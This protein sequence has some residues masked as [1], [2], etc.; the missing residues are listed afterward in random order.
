MARRPEFGRTW[1]GNAWLEALQ[2][3]DYYTNRLPRGRQYAR[4][5]TVSGVVFE[6]CEVKAEVQGRRRYP[7]RVSIRF[8]P[9]TE[10]EKRKISAIIAG[11]PT[12]A[13]QLSLG[14]L[15]ESLLQ[16]M[17]EAGVEPFPEGWDELAASCSCP[18]WAN[19]CK[20]LAAVYYIL[21]NEIDKDPFLV[22]SLRGMAAAELSLA[23]GLAPGEAAA[24]GPA[25]DLVFLLPEEAVPLETQA[26]PEGPDLSLKPTD[27]RD[28]LSLLS[29]SPLFWDKG[30]FK[31]LLLEMYRLV[32]QK[33]DDAGITEDH[34]W[35]RGLDL[36]LV[37]DGSGREDPFFFLFSRSSRGDPELLKDRLRSQLAPEAQL[38][39]LRLKVPEPGEEAMGSATRRG[40]SVRAEDLLPLLMT[41]SPETAE[42]EYRSPSLRFFILA[43]AVSMAFAGAGSFVPRVVP[44]AEHD[45]RIVYRPLLRDSKDEAV[46]R[47]LKAAFPPAA[48]FRVPDGRI[49]SPD[50]VEG[51]LAVLI[52]RMVWG[53]CRGRD[54]S[55]SDKTAQAF[56]RGRLYR[57]GR[58]EERRTR[59]SVVN[60]LAAL[61]SAGAELALLLRI[62]PAGDG[63]RFRLGLEAFSRNDPVSAPLS[64]R[65][66][67]ESEGPVFG[68][69]AEQVRLETARRLALA[70]EHLPRLTGVLDSRGEEAPELDG[71]A[72]A[73]LLTQTA[74]LLNLMGIR[75]ALSKQLQELARPRPALR[76]ELKAVP[77]EVAYL[78]LPE[79]LSFEWRVALGDRDISVEEFRKLASRATGVVKYR[80]S[81]LLLSPAEARTLLKRL[82]EPLPEPTPME[83]I[84]WSMLE[85]KGEGSPFLPGR[86]L[87]KLLESIGRPADL[88]MPA[89][90]RAELRPYQER[91]VRWLYANTAHGFGACLA[92]DMG[93]GKTVQALALLLKLKE[94]GRLGKPALVVCPTTVLGN[95]Q[96]EADRFAPT[97]RVHVYYGTERR[98]D[99]R[100]KDLVL[101]TYGTLRRDTEK[102]AKKAW[103]ALIL[104]EAQNIKNPLTGQARAVK[105]IQCPVRLALSGTPVENRLLELWSIF[106][107]LNPGYLGSRKDFQR[108]FAVPIE[109][110]RDRQRA[111]HLQAAISPFV[112]R[113]LKTDGSVIRDL[114]EKLVL[115]EFCRLTPSQASLYQEVVEEA[116][117]GIEGSEGMERRGLVLRLI[118]YLKQICN[119]PA[120][121]SGQERAP[122]QGSGKSERLLEL[123]ERLLEAGEKALVFTQ[124]RQMGHLLVG[125]IEEELGELPLFLHGGVPRGRRD[126]MV[127][128]F[129]EGDD[130]R[131]MVLSLKAGGVGLNLTAASNVVHYDLWW[132]PAV[133]DQATDRTF[134]IG[135]TRNVMVHRLL[136][137]D[138]FEEKIDAMIKAKRELA[139]ITVRAGET[140]ITELGD[141]ELRE[142]FRL[143]GS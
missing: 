31:R 1:W 116:M 75:V 78:S 14:R 55:Y 11:S 85:E 12:L 90:L 135:Q 38:R 74:P 61:E 121:F 3:I 76:A 92:D 125:L 86:N 30:D 93:L 24:P 131:I 138:T 41:L 66:I 6:D 25:E 2:R 60:W 29:P 124:F 40:F 96:K 114:P 136:C 36:R 107:F 23:A 39:E 113:R 26:H 65:E 108:R 87:K 70:S 28:L 115:D 5:G 47:A 51:L 45:F 9:F 119:H 127:R 71:E 132:N 130:H 77:G 46:C 58:F 32:R 48:A 88:Q 79:L 110:Y 59:M 82:Q 67:C 16:A 141:E 102:F 117:R 22:F 56:F 120:Q 34:S 7:Y 118:L 106:D 122:R 18:D 63:S 91:G 37:F 128:D 57:A 17:R 20:H 109:R 84:Q 52:T 89:S 69:P 95:W 19:P 42:R 35:L 97:L 10:K 83:V 143:G 80:G 137:L 123:L 142:I 68:R 112:M 100:G 44:E 27:P 111:R 15:P 72:L 99:L 98:L 104:D 8:R 101:T 54:W 43:A 49:L 64:W 129:Q 73:E 134:R 62:E 140:W 33:V 105:S 53:F 21:A 133:E 13:M 50:S 81:Y 126:R 103:G 139:D 94:E 4:G